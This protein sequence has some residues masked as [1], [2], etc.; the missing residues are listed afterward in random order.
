MTSR[1]NSPAVR[2]PGWPL[3]AGHAGGPHACVHGRPHGRGLARRGLRAC[4]V[5]EQCV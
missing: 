5:G 3:G 4:R 2:C 1:G